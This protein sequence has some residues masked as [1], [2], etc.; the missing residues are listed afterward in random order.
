MSSENLVAPSQRVSPP[1]TASMV[2]RMRDGGLGLTG[3]AIIVRIFLHVVPALVI[4]IITRT[5]C[6][7][8]IEGNPQE[9]IAKSM[10]LANGRQ[11]C[12]AL[13]FLPSH[14]QHHTIDG[15]DQGPSIG[16]RQERR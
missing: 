15:I 16:H 8:I 3:R 12:L 2:T 7:D 13:R 1:S 5:S 10:A 14:D 4:V 9:P 11:Y 6:N